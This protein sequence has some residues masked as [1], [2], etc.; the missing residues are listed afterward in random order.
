MQHK[1]ASA[2]VQSPAPACILGHANPPTGRSSSHRQLQSPFSPH[3]KICVSSLPPPPSNQRVPSN[4]SWLPPL[5]LKVRNDAHEEFLEAMTP[6]AM[7]SLS[8]DARPDHR[9]SGPSPGTNAS[10]AADP[11]T[12]PVGTGEDQN[13]PKRPYAS[14]NWPA[15]RILFSLHQASLTGMPRLPDQATGPVICVVGVPVNVVLVSSQAEYSK[16]SLG[17]N[18]WLSFADQR[19]HQNH[20]LAEPGWVAGQCSTPRYRSDWPRR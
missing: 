5:V 16:K 18:R 7:M 15:P 12:R 2:D 8:L 17:G 14:R 20:S 3:R 6:M 9:E 11:G 1:G 19:S 4:P 10:H 13:R